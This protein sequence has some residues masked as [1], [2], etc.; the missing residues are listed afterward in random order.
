MKYRQTHAP[1]CRAFTL[2]ETLL[3]VGLVSVLIS[4]FLT[5]FVPARGLVQQALT[6]QESD[7]IVSILRAEMNTVHANE[8][9][10][11]EGES[12]PGKYS[13]AFDKGFY[14]ITACKRPETA[15][16]V[17]SYRADTTRAMK[18]DGTYPA[19]PAN[20][21]RPGKDTMLTSIACPMDSPLHR[22]DIKHAVGPV[23]LV[24]L[25][26]IEETTSGKY[27]LSGSPG[28]I[29]NASSPAKYYS[30]PNSNWLWG[31]AIFCRADFYQMTPPNPARYKNR[32]WS[33][34]GRPVFSANLS[35]RR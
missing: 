6:K 32:P 14:W 13:T 19:I 33:R 18:P 27:K 12:S 29:A 31:G 25:T 11:S 34:V 23:F 8:R 26:Q 10:T 35:F 22:D 24:K 15:I 21:S 7:R 3:A 4:I 1:H 2:M 30:Q 9:S 5:V 16:V 17:F 20:V 28:V